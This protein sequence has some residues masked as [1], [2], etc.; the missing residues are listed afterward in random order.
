VLLL[1]LLDLAVALV[2]WPAAGRSVQQDSKCQG[3]DA[4]ERVQLLV[5]LAALLLLLLVTVQQ[6]PLWQQ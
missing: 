6:Q 2:D 3:L 1:L 4:V 5:L